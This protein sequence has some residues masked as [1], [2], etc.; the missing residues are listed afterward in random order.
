MDAL[1]TNFPILIE[2]ETT[3]LS[4]S[5]D[6]TFDSYVFSYEIKIQNLSEEEVTLRK[7]YWKITDSSGDVREVSGDGVVGEEPTLIPFDSYSY[8]SGVDFST[9]WGMMEGYY[10][11]ETE[12]GDLLKVPIEP[13]HFSAGILLQ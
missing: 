11:F 12:W 13:I 8:M 10:I 9:P 7:R 3:Y 4:G 2:V 6:V 5:S 1:V